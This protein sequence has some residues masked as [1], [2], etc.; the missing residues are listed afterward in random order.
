MKGDKQ[1]GVTLGAGSGYGSNYTIFGVGGYYFPI[2]G[3]SVGLG[4]RGWFGSDPGINELTVP[5]TYYIPLHQK[6]RPY[7]GVLYRRTF[8][9]SP[10]EDYNTFGAR[11]GVAM[12]LSPNSYISVGWVQ[13]YYDTCNTDDCSNGYP[14]FAVGFSF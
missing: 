7:A 2:D 14:E 5:V 4:Y 11:V 13:E 8:I 3:L 1:I 12:T 6:F 10:F 9:D